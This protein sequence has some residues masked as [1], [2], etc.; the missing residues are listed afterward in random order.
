MSPNQLAEFSGLQITIHDFNGSRWVA[1]L[2]VGRGL[3]YTDPKG[4]HAI[5]RRHADEFTDRDT[6]QGVVKTSTPGGA[7]QTRLFSETGVVL[8]TMFANT[9]RA[10]DFRAWAK[11]VLAREVTGQNVPSA[12]GLESHMA[13]LADH[14]A[15]L[16]AVSRQ[17]AAK[18]EVTSRYIALLE[19]NQRGKIRVTPEVEAE[20]F[21][22]KAQGLSQADIARLLRISSATVSLLLKGTFPRN[23]ALAG[24][25]PPAQ[26]QALERL[27]EQERATLLGGGAEGGAA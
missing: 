8:L 13:R 10:K 17:Q 15:D 16:A 19:L 27:I 2:D 20:V 1:A 5:Y 4:I 6:W 11:R 22:L 3:G 25:S 26:Q 7:Q 23:A 14:M 12:S 21:K 24:H 9:P 18:L